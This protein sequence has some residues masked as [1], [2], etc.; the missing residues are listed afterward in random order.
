ML[1]TRI[2]PTRSKRVIEDLCVRCNDSQGRRCQ[3][4]V[5]EAD[6]STERF[7]T[8]LCDVCADQLDAHDP[9]AVTVPE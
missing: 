4:T 9:I 6:G 3:L 1:S 5:T 7:D 8:V 2:Q